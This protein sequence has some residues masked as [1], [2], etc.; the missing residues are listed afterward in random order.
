MVRLIGCVQKSIFIDKIAITSK[1]GAVN[2]QP[3]CFR[4]RLDIIRAGFCIA[5]PLDDAYTAF[6][7]DDVLYEERGLADHRP[8]GSFIPAY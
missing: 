3:I 8:P 5:F 4:M 7:P 1:L 2:P 6:R